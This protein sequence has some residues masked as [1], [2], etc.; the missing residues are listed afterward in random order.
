MPAYKSLILL[1]TIALTTVGTATANV[2]KASQKQAAVADMK[3]TTITKMY[4]QDID[5][6][7]MSNPVVLQQYANVDLLAAMQ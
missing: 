3:I 7:G 2:T 5:D 1:S 6:Q 4:Q